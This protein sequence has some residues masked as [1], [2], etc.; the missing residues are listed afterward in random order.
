MI[1]SKEVL[2]SK[3]NNDECYT[4]IYGVSPILEYVKEGWV[5]WCPFD[6]KDSNFVKLFEENGIKVI[7]SH[8]SEGCDFFEYEPTEHWDCI[9]SNPPFT[10]KRKYFERALQLGKP[11]ALIMTNTWLNDSAPKQLF[12][13]KDLQLLM[14]DKR[15]KFENSGVVQDKI[16]F[17]SSYYCY[18]FLPK[19]IIMKELIIEKKDIY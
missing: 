5:V 1:N 7:S 8:I 17:S 15:M 11:F 19:Q 4:P 2:Y 14:F 10:N 16:T 12:M 13:E 6:T 9:I 18:N 3:G